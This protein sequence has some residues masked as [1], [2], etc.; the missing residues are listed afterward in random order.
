M[1]L[2]VV[3][4]FVLLQI[5]QVFVRMGL[6]TAM[7][8]SPVHAAMTNTKGSN[9]KTKHPCAACNISHDDL[10]DS[11]CNFNRM[12]RTA[13]GIDADIAYAEAGRTAHE[14]GQRSMHRGVTPPDLP[15]PLKR[16]TFDRVRQIGVD[17]LHQDALVSAPPPT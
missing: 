8:D 11:Q 14:R 2:H 3:L 15:N 12:R 17:I 1:P 7:V 9:A 10:K 4:I 6:L 5:L 13:E 16:V